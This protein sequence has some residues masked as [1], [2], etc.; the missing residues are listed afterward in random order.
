MIQY[1]KFHPPRRPAISWRAGK[2]GRGE[3]KV[4]PFKGDDIGVP[5][6]C[7]WWRLRT[8]NEITWSAT[9]KSTAL[10]WRR[11]ERK[12][13]RKVAHD[14]QRT[15]C[16]P[17]Q[18]LI[19]DLTIPVFRV[20]PVTGFRPNF[21]TGFSIKRLEFVAD[22]ETLCPADQPSSPRGRE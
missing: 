2:K 12:E 10:G 21:I 15:R 11:R 19:S 14:Y 22:K 13:N 6:T 4:F 20:N 8:K 3:P 1:L 7:N 9:G 16:V 17:G 18:E 5:G